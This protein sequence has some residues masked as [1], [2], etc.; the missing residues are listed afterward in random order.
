MTVTVTPALVLELE[1]A[2]L[3]A[4]EPDQHQFAGSGQHKQRVALGRLGS[5]CA[6]AAEKATRS[7]VANGFIQQEVAGMATVAATVMIVL[8]IISISA[9][10][11]HRTERPQTN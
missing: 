2:R 5:Q 9:S 7:V 4:L 3:L 1:L 10:A 8:S 11:K 6:A